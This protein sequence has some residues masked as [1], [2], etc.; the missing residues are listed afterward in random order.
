MKE[1]L[2]SNDMLL[3]ENKQLKQHCQES[4]AAVAQLKEECD[5]LEETEE[6][7]RDQVR[8]HLV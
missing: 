1:L 4:D 2:D 5:K 6:D 7:L 3:R 8:L